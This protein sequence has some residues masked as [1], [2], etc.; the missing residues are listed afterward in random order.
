MTNSKYR[1]HR[2]TQAFWGAVMIGGV[3]GAAVN[4]WIAALIAALG[5][6]Q[7]WEKGTPLSAM[8]ACL[9]LLSEGCYLLFNREWQ[10]V[11]VPAERINGAIAKQTPLT[12][13]FG[14][15]GNQKLG[16]DWLLDM[17]TDNNLGLLGDE[18]EGKSYVLRL[19]AYEFV[20]RHGGNCRLF[21]HD[22]EDGYGHDDDRFDWFGLTKGQ[23]LFTDAHDLPALLVA[24]LD[25]SK[26]P[27]LVLVDELNNAMDELDDDE[28][29]DVQQ[30]FKALRNRGKK[31][32]VR[33]VIGTQ[34]GDVGSLG[35]NSAAIRKLV[36]VVFPKLAFRSSSYRLLDLNED[37]K[38]NLA[39]VQGQLSAFKAK[40]EDHP[41]VVCHHGAISLRGIPHIDNL[42][43]KLELA[44][45]ETSTDWFENWLANH[46]DFSP[47]SYQS[48][49]ALT[50][51]VNEILR[52]EK[53]NQISDEKL[54]K[55]DAS[56]DLRY[57]SIQEWHSKNPGWA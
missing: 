4:P 32:K 31:R 46:P 26:L 38:D 8:R 28:K 55:R 35:L 10:F 18:G 2:T 40:D 17:A 12:N 52:F 22:I 1:K 43:K 53:A 33:F 54:I 48:V 24:A 7:S 16:T 3:M 50:D 41:V 27:T 15:K 49:R 44:D 47:H 14:Y 39:A 42:P 23:H 51:A 34:D 9:G 29:H 57:R 20:K 37:E 6:H 13:W 5:T 11:D 21:I 36:W 56:A 19:L 45:S 30:G 25:D